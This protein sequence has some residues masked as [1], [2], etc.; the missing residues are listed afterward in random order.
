M[1]ISSM[2][3]PIASATNDAM[4]LLI[5]LIQDVKAKKPATEIG[6]DVLPKLITV[7]GETSGFS[8]EVASDKG[9]VEATI[10]YNLGKLIAALTG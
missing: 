5:V 3:M 10:G 9:T 7:L 2:P 1:P 4:G 8:A 6:G